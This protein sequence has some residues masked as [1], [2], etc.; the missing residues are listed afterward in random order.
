MWGIVF[1]IFATILLV[2][3]LIYNCA[4]VFARFNI[5]RVKNYYTVKHPKFHRSNY[6]KWSLIKDFPSLNS[7]TEG[8]FRSLLDKQTK[9]KQQGGPCGLRVVTWNIEFGYKLDQIISRLHILKPDILLLQE[10]DCVHEE[11][12]QLS[13]HVAEEIAK[14]LKMCYVWSGAF[15]YKLNNGGKGMF[16]NAVLSRF[17]IV[18]AKRVFINE[19]IANYPKSVLRATVVHPKE[20]NILCYSVHLE[21][22]TGI[23]ERSRQFTQ[24]LND[25]RQTHLALNDWTKSS[26]PGLR[27]VIIAGDLNTL[28]HNASRVSPIHCR[29][30]YRFSTL[31]MTESQWFQKN[32][33]EQGKLGF[34]FSDAFDKS[35]KHHHTLCNALISAKF[36][37]ILLNGLGVV[38]KE[39][40]VGDESDHWY[41]LVDVEFRPLVA[42]TDLSLN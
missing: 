27:A 21:A 1:V 23:Y 24:V 2:I 18:G 22:V 20:G 26:K 17:D 11:N 8:D 28:G 14:S 19:V 33:F 10:C 3:Q 25:W 29:D 41:V 13:L 39:I 5:R 6:G 37:W 16:G 7:I 35:A 15:H 31:G 36:D 4:C 9:E 32:F 38:H 30:S 12:L 42:P 40:G 34:G